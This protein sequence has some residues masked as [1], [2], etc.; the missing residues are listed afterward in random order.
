MALELARKQFAGTRHTQSQGSF[1]T[2]SSFAATFRRGVQAAFKSI[3]ALTQ[4]PHHDGGLPG[5]FHQGFQ[6]V[7]ILMPAPDPAT[8]CWVFQAV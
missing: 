1:H 6:P 4:P 5:S 2:F 8:S 7:F 3:P